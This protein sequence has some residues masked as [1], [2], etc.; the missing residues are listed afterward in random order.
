MKATAQDAK[1]GKRKSTGKGKI[2]AV[3]LVAVVLIA[4]YLFLTYG[5]LPAAV[6]SAKQLNSST[7]VNIMSQKINSTSE[8][9]LSYS[10]SIVINKVD[11]EF[12]FFYYKYGGSAN[13]EI[14]VEGLPNVGSI[15]A[16]VLTYNN[17]GSG[18]RCITYNFTSPNSTA[19]CETSQYPYAVY[20]L[21]LGYFVNVSSVGNVR[22]IS[23]GLQ[24]FNG[25]P[26]YVVKGSGSVEVNG[27][28]FNKTGFIPS[29]FSFD[30]CL[31]AKYNVPLYVLVNA[32]LTNGDSV[33]FSVQNYGLT[34]Q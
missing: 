32:N 23:Y 33:D 20:A 7:L 19:S 3:V 14:R 9:N 10:G 17:S 18:R 11:P 6:L 8:V 13:S 4:A 12:S 29:D 31:S 15:E 1:S 34:F 28:L 27:A 2:A 21:V 5:S 16:S 30:T 25:Q 26:C 24:S 22:T